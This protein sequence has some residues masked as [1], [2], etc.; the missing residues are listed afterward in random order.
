[1]LE[2]ALVP[3]VQMEMRVFLAERGRALAGDN[4]AL[5]SL[6]EELVAGP[7]GSDP[8]LGLPVLHLRLSLGEEAIDPIWAAA[9]VAAQASALGWPTSWRAAFAKPRRVRFR[10][11]AAPP[12]RALSVV[13]AGDALGLDLEDPEGRVSHQRLPAPSGRGSHAGVPDVAGPGWTRLA[14]VPM[15]ARALWVVPAAPSDL[16]WVPADPAPSR[17]PLSEI[18]DRLREAL[19]LI[20]AYAP[21][22]LP[23]VDRVVHTIVAIDCPPETSVSRSVKGHHGV[24]YASFPADVVHTAE[25][26]VHEAAHQ[27]FNILEHALWLASPI[28]DGTLYHSPYVNRDRTI[29]RILFAYHAFANVLLFHRRCLAGGLDPRRS[30]GNELGEQ[31]RMLQVVD[32]HLQRTTGLRPAGRILYEALAQRV[33]RL[34]A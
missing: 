3:A 29:D 19:D 1:M 26:L 16:L 5:G 8:A 31:E 7:L 25:V 28:D 13:P 6:L 24:V 18:L 12:A 22:Y 34:A 17:A 27:Y 14:L 9:S 10:R 33:G 23:W 15:E 11:W 2:A 30:R 20:R 32:S 21:D 4:G